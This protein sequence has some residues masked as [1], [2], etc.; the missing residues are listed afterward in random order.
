MSNKWHEK[1]PGEYRRAHPTQYAIYHAR[2]RAAEKAPSW[3]TEICIAAFYSIAA[4]LRKT[5]GIDFT[6]DHVIPLQGRKVT[7]LHVRDNLQILTGSENSRKF[8]KFVVA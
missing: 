2:R 4:R 7:G 1:H 6:V 5:T 3:A 8:N